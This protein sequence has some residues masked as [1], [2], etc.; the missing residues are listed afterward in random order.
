[1]RTILAGSRTI[2]R[3]S[4]VERAVELARAAGFDITEVVSGKAAGADTLGET[5]ARKNGIPVKEFPADWEN[6]G[7][8]HAVIAYH[9]NKSAYDRAAGHYRNELMAEYAA[10][11]PPGQLIAVRAGITYGTRDMIDR[12]KKRGLRIFIYDVTSQAY[13]DG[14]DWRRDERD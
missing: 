6:T 10:E 4:D 5:W 9:K 1:M 14:T 2:H 7:R 8:K 13:F 12:A 3:L 11:T